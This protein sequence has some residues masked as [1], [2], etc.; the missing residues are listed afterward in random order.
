SL[1]SNFHPSIVLCPKPTHKTMKKIALL[2]FTFFCALITM[3]AQTGNYNA[4]Y[5][6]FGSQFA[7]LDKFN[8]AIDSVNKNNILGGKYSKKLASHFTYGL[9]YIGRRG[10]IEFGGNLY[11]GNTKETFMQADDPTDNV[12]E[13][14][15]WWIRQRLFGLNGR[16]GLS[17]NHFAIGADL[18]GLISNFQHLKLKSDKTPLWFINYAGERSYVGSISPYFAIVIPLETAI[19]RIEPYATFTFG[20]TSFDGVFDKPTFYPNSTLQTD[21]VMRFYGLRACLGFA[22]F[23]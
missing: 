3:Q 9:G 18:G 17:G 22:S 4:G 10:I 8:E 11:W 14:Y 2:F 7:D 20:N 23:D 15:N 12:N 19:I 21:M 13:S 16:I 5:V 1:F 6:H